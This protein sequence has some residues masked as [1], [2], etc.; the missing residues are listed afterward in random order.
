MN[1]ITKKTFSNFIL[2]NLKNRKNFRSGIPHSLLQNPFVKKQQRKDF[3]HFVESIYVIFTYGTLT[4]KACG[5][6]KNVSGRKNKL[7]GG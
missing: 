4:P 7:R 3:D 6:P 2:R 1:Q 5:G